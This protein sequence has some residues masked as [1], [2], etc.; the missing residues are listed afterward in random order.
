MESRNWEHCCG[1]CEYHDD[2]IG[3]CYADKS[4]HLADYTFKDDWCE[5]WG[6]R[7]EDTEDGTSL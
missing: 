6:K 4:P 3:V 5:C 1:N 2:F 7:T